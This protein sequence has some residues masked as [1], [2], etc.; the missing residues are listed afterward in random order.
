MPDLTSILA[1]VVDTSE[2]SKDV[3]IEWVIDPTA[4]IAG[5]EIQV[6]RVDSSG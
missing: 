5:Y 1:S 2:A 6:D 3:L 4:F